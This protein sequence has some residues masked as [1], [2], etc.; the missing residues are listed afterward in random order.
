MRKSL[1]LPTSAALLVAAGGMASAA[2]PQPYQPL[3]GPEG[4]K[5]LNLLEE[6]GYR[7]YKDFKW[8]GHKYTVTATYHGKLEQVMVDPNTGIITPT[9]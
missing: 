6:Q 9:G 8:D 4:T 1:M 3:P 2:I 5:A 7:N